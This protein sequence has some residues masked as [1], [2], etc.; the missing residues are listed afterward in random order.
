MAKE[1][2]Q[3]VV[4]VVTG[5]DADWVWRG[6]MSRIRKVGTAEREPCQERLGGRCAYGS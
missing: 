1:R 4:P 6:E 3:K 5:I 2:G